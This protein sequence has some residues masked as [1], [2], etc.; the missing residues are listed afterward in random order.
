MYNLLPIT[1]EERVARAILLNERP[2]VVIHVVDAKN[3]E[4]MLP[5][6]LQLVEAGLPLVLAVNLMDEAGRLGIEID[7]PQLQSLLGIPVRATALA[8]GQGAKALKQAILERA[9]P[10]EATGPHI[11]QTIPY[12]AV[13]ES[14]IQGIS[15]LLEGSYPLSRRTL[16]LLLLQDDRETLKISR[17]GRPIMPKRLNSGLLKPSNNTVNHFLL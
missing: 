14:A 10:L 1:E 17:S 12:P 2:A 16:A 6:T 8:N 3:L 7:I 5:M 4:R 13:I 11:D 9:T 15:N